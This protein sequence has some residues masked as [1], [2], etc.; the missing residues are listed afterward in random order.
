MTNEHVISGLIRKRAELAGQIED[1][2]TK[3]RQ[4]VIDLDAL[5]ATLRLFQPDIDL[6]EIRPKPIPPRH[7]AFRGEISRVVL[8]YLRTSPEPVSTT[9]VLKRVMDERGL[10]ISDTRLYRLIRT[11]VGACLRNYREQGIVRSKRLEKF[12]VWEIAR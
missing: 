11:R 3:L 4:L 8:E 6:A 10:N 9:A 5:D 7:H 1:A 12:V 2:Q